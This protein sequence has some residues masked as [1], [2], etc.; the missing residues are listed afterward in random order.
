VRSPLLLPLAMIASRLE[1][2]QPAFARNW[3]PPPSL[4]PKSVDS[5]G[6]KKLHSGVLALA[7]HIMADQRNHA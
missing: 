6:F 3:T 4:P 1:T 7:W 2:E 5:S